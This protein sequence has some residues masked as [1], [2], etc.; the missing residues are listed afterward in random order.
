MP[1][2][3]SSGKI[4]GSSVSISQLAKQYKLPSPLSMRNLIDEW[5]IP[6]YQDTGFRRR[7]VIPLE[8][9]Q[10]K[11]NEFVNDRERPLFKFRLHGEEYGKSELTV[12][13]EDQVSGELEPYGDPT[14]LRPD[15]GVLEITLPLLPDPNFNFNDLNTTRIILNIAS[16]P[17]G[18]PPE[19]EVRVEFET[20]EEEL[21]INNFPNVNLTRLILKLKLP[22]MLDSN[23]G[24][25]SLSAFVDLVDEAI[26]RVS[27]SK[28][29]G[30]RNGNQRGII[31]VITVEF[32][33]KEFGAT[34]RV[35]ID[36][37][38]NPENNSEVL[39]IIEVMKER[40][41]DDLFKEFIK[42]D[43]LAEVVGIDSGIV[44]DK[45]ESV[46]NDK[47][48][49]AL[50]DRMQDQ[51]EKPG[52][53]SPG[54]NRRLTRLLVG[55]DY[56]VVGVW[57][58]G[59]VLNIDYIGGS[60][61]DPFPEK[62]QPS[63]EP[64]LLSNI[65]HI[66]VL[67]MENRSFDH[68]LGY[69]SMHGGRTDVDG[70]RGGEKNLY[71][72][73]NHIPLP[74]TGT[75]FV[76]SPCHDHDCVINQVDGGKMDGFVADFA[77][78]YEKDNVDPGKIMGYYQ[79]AQVP[80]YDAL[81]REFLICQRWFCSHP[82]PTFPNR[83][84]Q[85]TGRLNRDGNGRHELDNP[86][87]SEGFAPVTSKTIFDHLSNQGVS[88]RYY[89]HGYCFLRLFERYTFDNKNI[90]GALDPGQGFF[91][92]AREGTLPSV[93]FIDPDFIDL[94]PGNDDH[95]PTDIA[96]GQRLI[97]QVV[98][99]LKNGPL[100]SKTLLVITYDEHG[101][102]FDHVPP[103][104]AAPV[105]GVDRY[106]PR[107]PSF[108]ISPWV[109]PGKVSNI[110]FDHTSILKTIARRFLSN[111]PPDMGE[112][113][114]QANDLS[115]VLSATA[116]LGNLTDIPLPPLPSTSIPSNREYDDGDFHAH[117]LYKRYQFFQDTP[118]K[119]GSGGGGSPGSG[120]GGGDGPPPKEN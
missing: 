34:E 47:L 2:L 62:P 20:G 114:A 91:T 61:I 29:D 9:F 7:K 99:A 21:K 30:G 117:L 88:W 5:G 51:E 92:A 96:H 66:V 49:K 23:S 39:R 31:V 60:Q 11:F 68:M 53:I 89:E 55:G 28:S 35:V 32:R 115:M 79:A 78:R 72:G 102:F 119:G 113:M 101:G 58:D 4:V 56:Q 90:V 38:S 118:I 71:K 109:E 104:A 64:G 27:I 81:A 18:S 33:G 40:L 116:R 93:S 22:I 112:R 82:G 19:I 12:F 103:P 85:L 42:T 13:L 110:V 87:L 65:D 59:Q 74:L 17:A 24:L 77:A 46:L 26:Q 94:P 3:R 107:V 1:S 108:V 120:G 100:W 10:Q 95:P 63:L 73:R 44:A 25:V 80:V 14:D 57:S 106:G 8:V 6:P 76:E 52:M 37:G 75:Q 43:A 45:I 111:R 98:N 97:A 36:A 54:I 105:S 70:L 67:M 83:F 16:E 50:L 41:K 48:I 69:L 15:G 86:S 84:Y